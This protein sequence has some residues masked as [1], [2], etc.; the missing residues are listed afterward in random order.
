MNKVLIVG[1]GKFGNL[2][3]GLL[4][5]VSIPYIC[6][7]K[8]DRDLVKE[9]VGEFD[10]IILAIPFPY[11]EDLTNILKQYPG[12][13][14]V[15][16]CSLK[17]PPV[18][19]YKRHGL[20]DRVILTHP[21]W[22]PN[23]V[24]IEKKHPLEGYLTV[25]CGEREISEYTAKL[26]FL[27]EL[28]GSFVLMSPEQHDSS[29]AMIQG[30]PFFVARC[31]L[32]LK[33]PVLGDFLELVKIE[34]THSLDL[35]RTI[36]RENPFSILRV[37]QFIASAYNILSQKFSCL[38]SLEDFICM[39]AEGLLLEEYKEI[40][41]RLRTKFGELFWRVVEQ[42]QTSQPSGEGVAEFLQNMQDLL[43]YVKG[44]TDMPS[45]LS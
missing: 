12:A 42:K 28:G 38:S 4:D 17:T 40:D 41:P 37:E 13:T 14:I 32:P 30:L 27:F 16:V 34:R 22:G 45:S 29:M 23:S 3:S 5:K 6:Y 19:F 10:S 43:L 9:V 24:D 2:L 15:D 21:L 26:G 39:S 1:R 35:F 7:D 8:K 36:V 33:D 44:K 31:L 18:D 20:L 25:I 11:G